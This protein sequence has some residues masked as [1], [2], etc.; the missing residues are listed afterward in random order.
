MTKASQCNTLKPEFYLYKQIVHTLQKPH[1]IS[2]TKSRLLM[3]F[4]EITTIC[5]ENITKYVHSVGKI[6][7]LNAKTDDIMIVDSNH[8]ALNK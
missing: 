6:E 5:S 2:I 8:F 3:M 4:R 1:N 7:S